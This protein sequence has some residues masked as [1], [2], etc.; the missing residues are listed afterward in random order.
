MKQSNMDI[1]TISKKSDN[2]MASLVQL[3]DESL[4]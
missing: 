4:K 2:V 3:F 1:N